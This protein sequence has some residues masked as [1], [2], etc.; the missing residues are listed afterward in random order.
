VFVAVDQEGQPVPVP[1]S[2]RDM[3]PQ[4]PEPD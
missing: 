3:L 2:W 4:W 1:D